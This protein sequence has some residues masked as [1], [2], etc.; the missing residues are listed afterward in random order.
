[1]LL[2]GDGLEI[3]E[4]GESLG[5]LANQ[6]GVFLEVSFKLMKGHQS[7]HEAYEF[8]QHSKVIKAL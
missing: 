7:L 5:D 2:Q 8:E 4:F 1:M 3:H 6:D